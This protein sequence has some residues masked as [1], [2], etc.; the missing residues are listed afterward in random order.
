VQD[1]DMLHIQTIHF[2]N[3]VTL[4]KVNCYLYVAYGTHQS[5]VRN[6]LHE[7]TESSKSHQFVFSSVGDTGV[8]NRKDIVETLCV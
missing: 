7:V 4:M 6:F 8:C 2:I 1:S 5:A 3:S